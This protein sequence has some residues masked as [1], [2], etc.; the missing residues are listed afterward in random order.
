MAS[1]SDHELDLT[2]NLDSLSF[3]TGIS[4]KHLRAMR[5]GDMTPSSHHENRMRRFLDKEQMRL[6]LT[7][8]YPDI[9]YVTTG[10]SKTPEGT[11]LVAG[12]T[13]RRL[14]AGDYLA[15]HPRRST[16]LRREHGTNPNAGSCWVKVESVSE[17]RAFGMPLVTFEGGASVSV[18][19]GTPLRVARPVDA[20]LSDASA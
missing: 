7:H 6:F 11:R 1:G 5:E 13:V 12:C 19:E 14:K 17:G 3:L 20:H 2:E 15:Y 18:N 9:P 4:V 16:R 8:T 10:W